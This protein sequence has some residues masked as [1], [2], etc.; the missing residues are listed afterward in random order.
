MLRE[1]DV[2][3]RQAQA[4]ASNM[5]SHKTFLKKT[6]RGKV[7]KVVREHY[8]RDDLGCGIRGC[9]ECYGEEDD[10]DAAAPSLSPACA[11]RLPRRPAPSPC[12]S[13]VAEPHYLVLD[14][15]VV[16]DQIDVLEEAVDGL[17]NVVVL[18]T[19][20]EEVRHRSSPVYKRLKDVIYGD[21]AR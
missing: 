2:V 17:D 11:P 4:Q 13:L 8:L 12:P 5:L 10:S 7:I 9:A 16:L 6:R 19:V 14:T 1:V 15:N 18:Q 20:L 21:V 3:V